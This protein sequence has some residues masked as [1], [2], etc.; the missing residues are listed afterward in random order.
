MTKHVH[1]VMSIQDIIASLESWG[2]PVEEERLMR[3]TPEFVENVLCRCLTQVTGIRREQLVEPAQHALL[4][5]MIDEK[6]RL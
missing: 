1:P 4:V 5:S 3:P 6:V 2:M